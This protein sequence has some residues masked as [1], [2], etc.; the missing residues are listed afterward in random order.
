MAEVG[1]YLYVYNFHTNNNMAIELPQT[2]EMKR[3]KLMNIFLDAILYECTNERFTEEQRHKKCLEYA[4]K[5][6]KNKLLPNE[7]TIAGDKD[8][9]PIKVSI[10]DEN[11]IRTIA[12]RVVE[13]TDGE[14]KSEDTPTGLLHSN[15]SEL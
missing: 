13:D 10:Y 1:Q 11:Q 5:Y 12:R 4:E 7:T 8:G 2:I 15:Q 9:E 14:P 3:K 6:A